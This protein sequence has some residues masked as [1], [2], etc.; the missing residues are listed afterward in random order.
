MDIVT[1]EKRSAMMAG[2]R[3]E[4]TRPEIL[5][6]RSLHHLGYRYRLGSRVEKT[7]PDIVLRKHKVAIFVHGCFW[8]QHE[9]CKLAYSNRQY[10][11]KWLIKFENN[12]KRDRRIIKELISSGWRVA[13]V[14]EYSTRNRDVLPVVIDRLNNFI[15]TQQQTY[16][17]FDYHKQPHK[18]ARQLNQ[19]ALIFTQ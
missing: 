14:W 16:F 17:E 11:D 15:R 2:I 7:K 3:S 19:S 10:S 12:A 1:P 4:N 9:S 18:P 8:H 13:V 6:R 5:V